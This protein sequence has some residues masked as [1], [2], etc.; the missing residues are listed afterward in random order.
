[1]IEMAT[2]HPPFYEI[3]NIY[4]IMVTISKLTEIIP[5]PDEIKSE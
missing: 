5:I 3:K 2:G 1:M 4:A